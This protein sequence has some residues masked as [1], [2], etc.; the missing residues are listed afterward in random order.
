[1][2]GLGIKTSESGLHGGQDK[3]ID[4]EIVRTCEEKMYN[5]PIRRVEMLVIVDSRR[6]R[7]RWK[8][9]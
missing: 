1:M 6:G 7:S 5:T 3:R 4:V 9:S 2:V 8:K